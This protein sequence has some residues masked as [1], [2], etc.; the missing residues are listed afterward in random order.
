MAAVDPRP[1]EV[2]LT[3]TGAAAGGSFS[4]QGH[5]VAGRDIN[6][7]TVN[8]LQRGAPQALHQLPR[9]IA[10]FTA[11]EQEMRTLTDL[12]LRDDPDAATA[13]VIC[14][15]AGKPGVGK[16]ALAIHVAHAIKDRF[17]DGQLYVDLRGPTGPLDATRVLDGFL[18]QLGV[19]GE[20]IPS[21]RDERAALYRSMLSDKRVLVI[22]DNAAS[23]EQLRPLLPGNSASAALVTS[24]VRLDAIEGAIV[25]EL[26]VLSED[27]AIELLRKLLNDKRIDEEPDA[28][29][30]VVRL[31]GML[32]LAVRIAGGR[33]ARRPQWSLES[34]RVRLADA[35]KRLDELSL[36]DREVR[37]SFRLSYD[38][39]DEDAQRLFRILGAI[40]GDDFTPLIPAGAFDA[41]LQ[42]V[43]EMLEALVD[44]QLLESP[45]PRRY[46]FHDLLR[47]F[48]EEL[49][50]TEPADRRDE[51]HDAVTSQYITVASFGQLLWT[52]RIDPYVTE[53]DDPAATKRALASFIDRERGNLS[54]AARAAYERERWLQVCQ[55]A[56]GLA[57]YWR[58]RA[59]WLEAETILDLALDA[60]RRAEHKPAEATMLSL[61]GVAYAEQQRWAEAE[62]A[63]LES[64]RV[65]QEAGA[66]QEEANAV[67]NVGIVYR[68]LGRY[69][70]AL[71][72]S[73][74]EIELMKKLDN[75]TSVGL[76]C[77][78]R[79]TLHMARNELPDAERSFR[80]AL[81]IH[82]REGNHYREGQ[83]LTNLGLLLLADDRIDEA[84][85]AI[86]NGLEA[87]RSFRDLDGEARCLTALSRAHFA[88]QNWAAAAT[89]SD[90]AA[91]AWIRL[92]ETEAALRALIRAAGA[93]SALENTDEARRRL[94][95]ARGI[96]PA[97][98][99]RLLGDEDPI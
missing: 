2:R 11:R 60:S 19:P 53:R 18:R 64:R 5:N 66:H 35:A 43:E 1:D 45:E 13:V 79:G 29:R 6:E 25:R 65:A 92:R 34:F 95:A 30:S 62:S 71:K 36:G 17:P 80:E 59:D 58:T 98:F 51:I 3:G 7:T 39:L 33:L 74:E 93:Y 70:E 86:E 15:V 8:M 16:S 99:E 63:F 12:L 78:N 27:S 20:D 82:R 23:E 68:N 28:A 31:C 76:A 81:E 54:A 88:A 46:R 50:A 47:L 56:T 75:P 72:Y 94:D 89:R 14:A 61:I 57:D 9:D 90:E 49:L 67:G 22:L 37:A 85:E 91:Q 69:D 55:L 44:E 83:V 52:G 24:R 96:D 40:P 10:D 32:P 41:P 97:G 4:Q 38:A 26:E 87:V 73:N 77:M 21:D 48:G 42:D 84:V